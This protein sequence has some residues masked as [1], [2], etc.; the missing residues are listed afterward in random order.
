MYNIAK[1]RILKVPLI[2]NQPTAKYI[3]FC[4]V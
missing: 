1:R 4:S 2:P 3:S